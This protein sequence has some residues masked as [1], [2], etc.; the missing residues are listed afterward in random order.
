MPSPRASPPAASAPRSSVDR[1]A[2]YDWE[3]ERVLRRTDQD[4][5]FYARLAPRP[6]VLELACGTGRVAAP[7][8]AVGL[9]VDEAM[10]RRAV[11]RGV[12]TVVGDMRRFSFG[13]RFTLIVVAW[14]SL[15]L[16][17]ALGRAACLKRV[18]EHLT[19]DGL[20]ALELTELD[21][22]D[23]PF[24]PV[25]S[26]EYASLEGALTWNGD[27]LTYSRRYTVGSVLYEHSITLYAVDE[28]ELIDEGFEVVEREG[29]RLA[30]R[31]AGAPR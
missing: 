4:L 9:D 16:L 28:Q 22:G 23:L 20:L 27:S 8:G 5:A 31:Y 6:P 19:D 11:A 25:F 17:D 26:D 14:N 12:P 1:A 13:T 24:T 18:A 10:V 2:L 21:A 29:P 7:L 3:C 15:Q 30:L